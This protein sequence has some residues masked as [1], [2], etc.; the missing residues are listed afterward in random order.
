MREGQIYI[1]MVPASSEHLLTYVQNISLCLFVY[2]AAIKILDENSDNVSKRAADIAETTSEVSEHT[3][4]RHDDG[5]R[6]DTQ[7]HIKLN[8]QTSTA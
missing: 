1:L 3:N 4:R 5:W 7:N 2:N 8:Y 6:F